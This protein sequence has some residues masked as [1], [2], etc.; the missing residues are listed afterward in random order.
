MCT[1][2]ASVSQAASHAAQTPTAL[3]ASAVAAGWTA[4]PTVIAAAATGAGV[5]GR[6]TSGS[7]GNRQALDDATGTLVSSGI[8]AIVDGEVSADE[9]RSHGGVLPG[10]RLR[11][12]HH[13]CLILA[14]ID[15][16]GAAVASRTLEA[17]VH[18][19]GPAAPAAETW[20]AQHGLA[21]VRLI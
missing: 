17:L 5:R 15:S 1:P 19:I 2:R 10:Q 9:I 7:N 18:R 16:S 14:V 6:V 12:V 3:I 21:K 4:V 20:E 13:V 11:L 8:H